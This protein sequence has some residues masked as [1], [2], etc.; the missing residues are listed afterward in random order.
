MGNQQRTMFAV[1]TLGEKS[2]IDSFKHKYDYV[3]DYMQ[4]FADSNNKTVD[5]DLLRVINPENSSLYKELESKIK[6]L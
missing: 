4:F 2:F 5:E 1:N 3:E 6:A